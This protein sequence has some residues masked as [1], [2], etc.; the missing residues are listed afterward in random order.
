M[1]ASLRVAVLNKQPGIS[2]VIR[3]E[4]L[5]AL[6]AGAISGTAATP[7]PGTR[8]TVADTNSK[9]S[10]ANEKLALAV[11]GSAG[12]NPGLWYGS[13]ALTRTP[14]LIFKWGGVNIA[15]VGGLIG[16]DA[17]A[18]STS[19]EGFRF[20]SGSTIKSQG[21]SN[22]TVDAFSTATAYDLAIA[23]RA[24][25][26]H[27]F[28]KGGAFT[29]WTL[30]WPTPTG[31]GTVFPS[32]QA[33]D[34]TS[35]F[36]VDYFRHS[37][38]L[39]L[40]SPIASDSFASAFGTTDGLGHAETT[41]L[42][43]GGAG[44]TW[45]SQ[46][47]TWTISTAKAAA[48]TLSGGLAVATVPCGTKDVTAE[49]KATR[50]A[51]NAGIVVRWADSSNYIRAYHDGTN[52]KLDQ[53]VATVVTNKI[54]AVATHSAGAVLRVQIEGTSARLFYN[55]ALIGSSSSIDSSLTAMLHGLYTTDTSNTLD[56]FCVFARG[57]GG[58]Y[59]I[60]DR[61]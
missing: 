29:Y 3:D 15:A 27:M 18:A 45:T 22:V 57:T 33:F 6:A 10:I 9:M 60:L 55:N 36:V 31:S 16:L 28:V 50:S 43:V 13:A 40:P 49:A 2:Y 21:D 23:L 46:L 42:G 38:T 56:D 20:T 35:D 12:G 7:G 26:L 11:G 4:F 47:G 51:G 14:G 37:D 34:A 39:W 24:A 32:I 52:A 5:T 25:G 1:R 48:A 58:E 44:L 8:T 17:N 30:I 19:T 41:G 54:T 61:Y 59:S 53:V